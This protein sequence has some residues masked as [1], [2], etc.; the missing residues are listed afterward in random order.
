MQVESDNLLYTFRNWYENKNKTGIIFTLTAKDKS[1]KYHTVKA[2]AP[3]RSNFED[4]PTAEKQLR[5]N[6]HGKQCAR[7]TVFDEKQFEG[8]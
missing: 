8:G 3:Y 6:A 2:Y 5:I 4:A 1:G 7:V